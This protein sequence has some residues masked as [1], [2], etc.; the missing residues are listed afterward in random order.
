MLIAAATLCAG[1]SRSH[2]RMQADV[3]GYNLVAQKASDPRWMLTD[4]TIEPSPESRMYDPYSPDHPPMP[5][6]D[7]TAHELLH[8]IDGKKGWPCWHANG[9]TP[10]VENPEW[11]AFLPRDQQGEVVLD[12]PGAVTTSRIHSREYQSQNE[13][14]YLAALNVSLERFAFDT[15]FFG[16]TSKFFTSNGNGDAPASSLLELTPLDGLQTRRLFATGSDLVVGLANS[17]VWEFSG[18]NSETTTTL[19]D[20]SFVQPLLRGAGR[21][22]VLGSLTT[23]E[24][25]LLAQVRDLVRFRREFY[26]QIATG[27]GGGTGGYYGLLQTLQQIRNGEANVAALRQS[28]DQLSE[29]HEIGR[30]DRLQVEQIE[31]TLYSTESGLISQKYNLQNQ[32]DRYKIA[33][34]LPPELPLQL[35]ESL[36]DQFNLIHPAMRDF[37]TQIDELLREV[38]SA[39]QA[40]SVEH[41]DKAK[42][43]TIALRNARSQ[44]IQLVND[45][46]QRLLEVLPER[47]DALRQL[48]QLPEVVSRQ[49][50]P[51]PLSIKDLDERVDTLRRDLDTKIAETETVWSVLEQIERLDPKTFVG[52]KENNVQPLVDWLGKISNVWLELSL[53]QA[54]GRLDTILIR[55][56]E[57]SYR[58]AFQIAQENRLDLM[59]ERARL[60]D[61]WRQIEITANDLKS[62]LD[63]TFDGDISTTNDNPFRFRDKTGRLRV[64]FQFDAPLTRLAERNTYRRALINY[65]R[66]RR[67]YM[68]FL[69]NLDADLRGTLRSLKLNELNLELSRARVLAAVNQVEITQLKLVKPPKPEQQQTATGGTTARDLAD[70]LTRLLSAQNDMLGNWIDH[71]V[72]R[73]NLDVDLGTMQ[74]DERGMWIDPGDHLGGAATLSPANQNEAEPIPPPLPGQPVPNHPVLEQPPL[75]RLDTTAASVP[76][77]RPISPNVL[78]LPPVTVAQ[79]AHQ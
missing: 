2:Y 69:D 13:N 14:L 15:Q 16:G 78:R 51:E 30:V 59:N 43:Q 48:A 38:R 71:E 74:L 25:D 73:V 76:T 3:E 8:H 17:F 4:Y 55:P 41:F 66:A 37:Q 27:R 11:R 58:T 1:C 52:E 31:T 6:D 35:D 50:S 64:G 60:V 21:A 47:H 65:Q 67:D 45:D 29:L 12:L 68:A 44:L 36:L 19:L 57:M 7:P 79:R 61:V 70:A 24:R 53:L 77:P 9:D 33:L 72:Q 46:Y 75:G 28:R 10:Y 39:E 62:T 49:L 5:P 42:Q 18:T 34:G 26:A 54:K 23:S 40:I 22:V 63:V 20:L 56:V 32:L